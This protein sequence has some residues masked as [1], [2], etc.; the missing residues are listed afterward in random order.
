MSESNNPPRSAP[1]DCC[2]VSIPFSVGVSVGE[3][4][5]TWRV[6]EVFCFFFK[7]MSAAFW[8]HRLNCLC[9]RLSTGAVT[10]AVITQDPHITQA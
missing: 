1:D 3:G 4:E 2:A 6:E 8:M 7:L 5:Q 9:G 10:G